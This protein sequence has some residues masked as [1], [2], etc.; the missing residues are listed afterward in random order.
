MR[1]VSSWCRGLGAIV[2]VVGL[3]NVAP[4]QSD[5]GPT[6]AGGASSS[7]AAADLKA[8]AA[9]AEER[10]GS[11]DRPA[12]AASAAGA[13]DA[14]EVAARVDE[15]LGEEVF[16]QLGPG[17]TLAPRAS[18]EVFLRRAALDLIGENP[19]PAEVIAFLLDET[20]DKR[21]RASEQFLAEPRF[22]HNWARY[23]RDVIFYRRA[24]DRSLITAP[25]TEEF[26][27]EKFNQN[28]GWDLIA[29]EFI[30][31]T[32]NIRENGQTAVIAAQDGMTEDVTA[33]ISRIF[34]GVQIQCAQCHDH[35]T[36]RWKREQFHE[37]AAFFP[38]VAVRPE[39][40]G[41]IRTFAV[42]SDDRLFPRRRMKN[43][44]RFG[45]PEH[46]MPDLNDPE[47]RGKLMTPT[48]FVTGQQLRLGA[49]DLE[50]RGTLADWMTSRQNPWF[51][52]AFVN[53]VWGEL[54]GEGFYEPLDDLG[55]DR[56]CSAP[57]TLEYLAGQFEAHQY[58]IKWLYRT[59]MSTQAYQ[60]ESRPR[61]TPEQT[62]F[63]AN[64][65][66]RLRSDQIFSCLMNALGIPREMLGGRDP[67]NRFRN[68]GPRFLFSRVFGYDP[69]DPRQE[70]TGTIPQA[71]LLMNSP[72]INRMVQARGRGGELGRLLAAE[73]ENEGAVVELYLR[74][75]ARRP[76][77]AELE[78]CLEH[79]RTCSSR[80]EAFE[81]LLWSLVNRTEFLY[82][83]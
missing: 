41:D 49:T 52:K 32:G 81:D 67:G 1:C 42:V 63:L 33:E 40:L 9:V 80:G 70:V 3:E 29:R 83:P 34:M 6:S 15:L 48:F 72:I 11:L 5:R 28:I 21:A 36:D 31:A 27:A 71:L 73:P 51:A 35:P 19:T 65:S 47:S 17:E 62:P 76:S 18:D 23:W 82:R 26:L 56:P 4:A 78:V 14:A 74:C 53:R 22:G 38:R 66:Q 59:V 10:A 37:L 13:G 39:R 16:A 75:L 44:G 46:Y 2:L 77:Q 64:C 24:D 43:D 68:N 50:R 60:R 61:R 58:D 20:V 57:R 30:V 55:P 79:I 7:D 69:S 25:A 45:Q 12:V 54:M 8:P